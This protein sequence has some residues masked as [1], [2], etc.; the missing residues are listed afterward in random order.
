[1]ICLDNPIRLV[2]LVN[3]KGIIGKML[4]VKR[5]VLRITGMYALRRLTA[6]WPE[7]N[8]SRA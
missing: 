7:K 8:R 1:M 5:G 2:E 4:N 6:A 3:I